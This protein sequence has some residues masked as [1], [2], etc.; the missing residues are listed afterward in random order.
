VRVT[1]YVPAAAYWW[2]GDA[3]VEVPPSPN[4]HAYDEIVAPPDA[5]EPELEKD[6][7]KPDTCEVK[8]AT[9]FAWVVAVP[10]TVAVTD[11]LLPELP[12]ASFA[13]T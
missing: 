11:A 5:L 3:T 6:T 9:G 4:F 13:T 8:E 2:V 12:S 1:V 10:V 7:D